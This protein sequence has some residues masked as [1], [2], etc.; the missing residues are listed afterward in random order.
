MEVNGKEVVIL[1][2][3]VLAAMNQ[4]PGNAL[5]KILVLLK[6]LNRKI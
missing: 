6:I 1:P 2:L 5:N 3:E 4:C